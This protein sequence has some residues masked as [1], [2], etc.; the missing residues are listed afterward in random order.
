MASKLKD[1]REQ[2]THT[3]DKKKTKKK[4]KKKKNKK[5]LAGS[6]A[7]KPRSD[8]AEAAD[9]IADRPGQHQGHQ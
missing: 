9:R 8:G 6:A 3:K 7:E 2:K 5:K 4:K 1:F